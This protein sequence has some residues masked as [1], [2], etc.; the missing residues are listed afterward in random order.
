MIP[1]WLPRCC[2][3][4]NNP[5][6][7]VKIEIQR[8]TRFYRDE[9]GKLKVWFETYKLKPK[10]E[11][12]TEKEKLLW[13]LYEYEIPSILLVP[14]EIELSAPKIDYACHHTC[15]SWM[16]MPKKHP[17]SI[18]CG[19]KTTL[20]IEKPIIRTPQSKKDW[21]YVYLYCAGEF[22]AEIKLWSVHTAWSIFRSY[23]L[24]R[25]VLLY[26]PVSD[27]YQIVVD[28]V[29]EITYYDC[30]GSVIGK[31]RQKGFQVNVDNTLPEFVTDFERYC[32]DAAMAY[33]RGIGY[34]FGIPVDHRLPEVIAAGCRGPVEVGTVSHF[35]RYG[36][37]YVEYTGPA[38]KP[39]HPLYPTTF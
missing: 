35:S 9:K 29:P 18:T 34:A 8:N 28:V 24:Q 30:T 1:E 14:G 39:G 31:R 6:E 27:R 11:W 4:W 37:G 36:P 25:S 7:L 19:K 22:I 3:E 16:A 12:M 2:F 23:Y 20:R 13:K 17:V 21:H 33:M 32:E 5:K 15:F 38:P 10:W 26:F